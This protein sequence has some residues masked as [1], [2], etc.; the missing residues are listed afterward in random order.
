M[1]PS[2]SASN[3]VQ[4]VFCLAI[5]VAFLISELDLSWLLDFKEK[6]MS[7]S[8]AQSQCSLGVYVTGVTN[9]NV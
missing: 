6:K 4:A 1:H 7:R 3:P 8:H 2:S 9:F 5:I